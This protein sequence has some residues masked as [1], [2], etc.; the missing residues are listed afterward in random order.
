M[1][2]KEIIQLI[3]QVAPLPLQ[4]EFDNSGLQVGDSNREVT[5]VLLAIDVTENVMDEAISL[6]CNLVISHHPLL[7]H[8][9]KSL[10]GRNYVERCIMKAIKYDIVVYAAHTNF[11]NAWNGVN[12]KLAE[13]LE[14]QNVKILEP[15][16]GALLKFVTTVPVQQAD[17]VRNA[18]FNAGA[19]RIGNY[20]SCSYNLTGQGTF[21]AQEG[22]HPHV[23]EVNKL[24]FEEEVRIETVFP[25]M[26]K[27]EVLRALMA[28]HPYEE[29]VYDL[30]PIVN[31]W[32]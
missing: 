13:K 10:T 11:D 30:Y 4:E 32:P 31:D 16:K 26:K 22:T 2:V 1:R 19:G 7:F 21:R 28:V 24:H 27:E 18:L 3:E 20:D 8:P 9:F 17:S 23:G 29:P 12:F 14:L 5:G 15:K 6:G 25:A